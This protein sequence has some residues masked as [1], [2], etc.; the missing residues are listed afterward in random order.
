MEPVSFC[1]VIMFFCLSDSYYLYNDSSKHQLH[2]LVA[3]VY[4]NE[5]KKAVKFVV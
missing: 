1:I 3:I 4:H 2:I 5:F